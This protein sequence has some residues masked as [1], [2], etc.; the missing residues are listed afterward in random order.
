VSNLPQNVTTDTL[1]TL[2]GVYGDVIRVK[3]LFNKRD[4]ALVE[5]QS[6]KMASNAQ[7]FLNQL[8]FHGEILAVTFSKKPSVSMPAP[9]SD[10]SALTTDY[11]DSKIHRFKH[12]DSRNSKNMHAPSQVLHVSNIAINTKET[13]IEKLFTEGEIK[14]IV[15]FFTTDR[16]MAYVCMKEVTHAVYALIR[17]HNQELNGRYLRVTFSHKPAEVVISGKKKQQQQ[18][19][20]TSAS[21]PVST[22][23]AAATTTATVVDD[24]TPGEPPLQQ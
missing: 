5:F 15:Q 22:A 9:E 19:Q 2:F 10:A 24:E 18:Q 3:I 4:T 16:R 13:E 6:A 17:V 20:Q 14:P 12:Q 11:S 8:H 21:A 1:F 23:A 7:M